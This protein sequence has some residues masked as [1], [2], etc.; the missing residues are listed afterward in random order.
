MYPQI[1]YITRYIRIT[2][3]LLGKDT[4]VFAQYTRN[5]KYDIY[6]KHERKHDFIVEQPKHRQTSSFG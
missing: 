5:L 4:R 3:M 1:C 2:V 6:K